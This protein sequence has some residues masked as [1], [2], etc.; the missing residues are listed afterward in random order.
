[1]AAQYPLLRGGGRVVCASAGE[2]GH[3]CSHRCQRICHAVL[4][5][6]PCRVLRSCRKVLAEKGR[7]QQCYLPCVR[8]KLQDSSGDA[9]FAGKKL[10]GDCRR[11][12]YIGAA[13]VSPAKKGPEGAHRWNAEMEGRL[14]MPPKATLFKV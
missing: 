8:Q 1:M 5:R 12:A 10:A 11:N 6:T 13:C 3:A 7:G 14:M 2:K 9:V 4:C